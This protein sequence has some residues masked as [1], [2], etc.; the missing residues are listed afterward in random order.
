MIRVFRRVGTMRHVR[1]VVRVRLAS[2][3]LG[4]HSRRMFF[5]IFFRLVEGLC[6]G[7]AWGTTLGGAEQQNDD[8]S[9][10]TFSRQPLP[11]PKLGQDLEGKMR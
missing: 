6:L 1:H 11:R 7:C 10:V 8:L 4:D 9:P 2:W 5:G 3:T